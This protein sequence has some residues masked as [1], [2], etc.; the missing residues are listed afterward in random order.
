MASYTDELGARL[1]ARLVA[2]D[3][4]GSWRGPLDGVFSGRAFVHSCRVDER[5]V[6]YLLAVCAALGTVSLT[7][8][9][10]SVGRWSATVALRDDASVSASGDEAAA[11]LALVACLALE[12]KP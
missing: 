1:Y 6:G 4:A 12:A 2:A 9:G 3:M 10:G 8:M 5:S 11:A 7:A